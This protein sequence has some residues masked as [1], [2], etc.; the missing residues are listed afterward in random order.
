M[1]DVMVLQHAAPE[2][3][4][5]IGDV[6]GRRGTEIRPIRV[7]Q[8]ARV[9]GSLGGASGLVVMGGAMS[10]YERER[11]PHIA[12]ELR[13]IEQ[14]LKEEV[15][16]LG[17]CL[18]SQM[19]AAALGARVYSSGRKEIGWHD[20]RL[21][22]EGRTD[23][24]WQGVPDRFTAF[25]WHGDIFDLPQGATSLASSSMTRIQSFRS[26]PS[27]YGLLFHL[28]AGERQVRDMVTTFSDEL[29]EAKIPSGPILEGLAR[30]AASV[31]QI[32][33]GVFGRWADLVAARGNPGK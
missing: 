31:Q 25:H 5:A 30:Q 26:G 32:G 2:G 9:P 13:L 19:L 33:E 10:V 3:P 7:D 20:V 1:A 8:G 18:G 29:R 14:A 11:Y 6:L 12:A 21:S 4:G 16:I 22:D 27:A 15:P 23:R 24:L 17:V 28:E